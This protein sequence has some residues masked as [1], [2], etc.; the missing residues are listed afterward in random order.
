MRSSTHF[1][2]PLA[3]LL[4][5][6]LLVPRSALATGAT[7]CPKEPTRTTIADG[8]VF[9][10]SNCNIYTSGDI[11]E[12]VFNANSGETYQLALAVT[13]YVYD[14]A[15]LDLYDPN[16]TLIK[17]VC[18][19]G[20]NAGVI[21]QTL[22]VTGSYTMEIYEE[23]NVQENYAVS[24]ERLYPFPPNAQQIKKLGKAVAADIFAPTDTNAFVF[25]GATTGSY[26]VTVQGTG[27]VYYNICI[28]L[29][30]PDG[31]LVVPSSGPNPGCTSGSTPA[32]IDFTPTQTGKYMGFLQA[33]G[34]YGTQAYTLEVS[35]LLGNCPSPYP[36]CTL[37]DGATYNATTGIL[38]MDFTVGNQS[39][40][41]WN[42]WL[43]SQSTVTSLFSVAQKIT[44]PPKAIVQTTSLSPQGTVGVLSTLTTPSQGIICSSFV[45]VNT[46]TP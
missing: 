31:T 37:A 32:Q 38:T 33:A 14:N 18:T 40:A 39:A 19:S 26:E 28:S 8:E 36:T 27:Y 46:G 6:L 20:S 9:S 5:I 15:C 25:S 22:T 1:A 29:Y 30:A 34:N 13:G 3:A 23:G 44:N 12:F 11:D 42:A 10:G 45:Q 16:Q 35:C 7:N 17:Q 43:N 24:L 4:F 2:L 41:T 21:D